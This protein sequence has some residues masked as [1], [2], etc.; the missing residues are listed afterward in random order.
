MTDCK[1]SFQEFC[2]IKE[3]GVRY[4]DD[5]K[6][7]CFSYFLRRQ[8]YFFT[9]FKSFLNMRLNSKSFIIYSKLLPIYSNISMTLLSMEGGRGRE[10]IPLNF[11]YFKIKFLIEF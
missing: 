9:I 3:A 7:F 1:M 5:G 10:R 2:Q 6:V 4:K 8:I 11:I